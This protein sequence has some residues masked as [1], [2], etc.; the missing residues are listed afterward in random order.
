[1]G[2]Q[3]AD[4]YKIHSVAFNDIFVRRLIKQ[5]FYQWAIDQADGN[6]KR[7]NWQRVSEAVSYYTGFTIA[8][9]T[10]RKNFRPASKKQNKP[11]N[12]FRNISAWQALYSFLISDAISYLSPKELA[13]Q[14]WPFAAFATLQEYVDPGGRY[15]FPHVL[16]GRFSNIWLDQIEQSVAMTIDF[17][18][19]EIPGPIRVEMR[20]Y[21]N[22]EFLEDDSYGGLSFSG[23][24]FHQ[25]RKFAFAILRE[26]YSQ[27]IKAL[28]LMQ[29]R[30]SLEEQVPVEDI[31]VLN[32]DG[33]SN[34]PLERIETFDLEDELDE[35]IKKIA[36]KFSIATNVIFL[37]RC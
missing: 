20:E 12:Q 19:T 29:T 27:Q 1:M 14:G 33:L 15:V 37:T 28:L 11:S 5:R 31:A 24:V 32:F 13:F 22:D 2:H 35:P 7:I 9:E 8:P 18:G 34:E 23:G 30:P 6:A 4:T 26:V 16:A 17:F 21:S 3:K 10:L 25:E 36:H